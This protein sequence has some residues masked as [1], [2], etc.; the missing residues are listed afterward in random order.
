MPGT[1]VFVFLFVCA[2]K[3]C[4][5]SPSY[6][7]KGTG[8]LRLLVEMLILL[9]VGWE[10]A[11]EPG[12]ESGWKLTGQQDVQ[13]RSTQTRG[14]PGGAL[15]VFRQEGPVQGR[16]WTKET[17]LCSATDTPPPPHTSSS[18]PSPT[19]PASYIFTG[20]GVEEEMGGEREEGG[21]ERER[22]RERVSTSFENKEISKSQAFLKLSASYHFLGPPTPTLVKPRLVHARALSLCLPGPRP[23]AGLSS[24]THSR[25]CYFDSLFCPASHPEVN[26][27]ERSV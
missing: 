2:L 24:G 27:T 23:R 21:R 16:Q 10:G 14:A 8:R 11:S 4:R 18:L 22:E 7:C 26:I 3:S 12:G 15:S 1:V 20:V 19:I 9:L 25:G 5:S 17:L 6:G 13:E